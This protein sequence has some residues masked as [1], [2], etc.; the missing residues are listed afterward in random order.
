MRL[1]N[2]PPLAGEEGSDQH[3]AGHDQVGMAVLKQVKQI[4]QVSALA[5]DHDPADPAQV[6]KACLFAEQYPRSGQVDHQLDP[7]VAGG[8][9]QVKEMAGMV[10]VGNQQA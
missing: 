8:F 1:K 4:M 7:L 3:R 2:Q 5:A 10:F 9:G 6:V